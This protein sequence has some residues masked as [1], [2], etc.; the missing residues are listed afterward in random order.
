MLRIFQ[1]LRERESGEDLDLLTVA[2]FLP[3]S[4]I[5]SR[6]LSFSSEAD[7]A[8]AAN[9]PEALIPIRI[10]L[11]TETHRIKDV[12]TWNVNETLLKPAHFA[13]ILAQDL[14]LPLDP[15][16]FQIEAAIHQQIEDL[17][18]LAE[19]EIGPAKGGPWK[20]RE[21]EEDLLS[22]E[23]GLILNNLGLGIDEIGKESRQWDWGIKEEFERI[24][25]VELKRMIEEKKERDERKK[26]N[27]GI[28]E[29]EDDDLEEE[30]S[31]EEDVEMED[32]EEDERGDWE[33][34]IRVIVDVSV[35]S[36]LL[37]LIKRG[38]FRRLKS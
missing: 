27:D 36:E 16:A 37:L 9:K 26:E 2:Y 3:P 5:L 28:V 4:P 6:F 11:E 24:K 31:E 8:R 20:S 18:G 22:L 35:E 13:K 7:L 32:D 10:E 29:D 17:G 12:F 25:E 23:N 38:K 1:D 30:F 34:D 14:G 21:G 15:Y 19:V 33:D